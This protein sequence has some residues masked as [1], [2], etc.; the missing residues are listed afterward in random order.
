MNWLNE[1]GLKKIGKAGLKALLNLLVPRWVLL[2]VI[3]LGAAA[4]GG[5]L[6]ETVQKGTFQIRQMVITGTLCAKMTPGMW[7]QLFSDIVTLPK[8]ETFFFTQ[9]AEGGEAVDRSIEVRF[10]DGSLCH[11]SGTM[12]IIL[13]TSEQKAIDLV[14]RH[15]YRTYNDL[16]QKLILPVVRNA[17]RLTANLMSARESYSEKRADFV[18][19]A[20]DQIQNGLYETEEETRKVVDPVSGQEVT[21]IFK[22]IKRDGDGSPIYQH[23][24]LDGVGVTLANFEVKRFGYAEK[25][26]AQIATQQ[27]ALMAVATA[28][29]KAQQAEQEALM[30]EAEGKANVAREKYK[31]EQK[32]VRAI[33]QAQQRLEVAQ[34]DR[35]AAA[36]KKQEE[37]LLGQGEAERKR[38]I[39]QA[40]GALKQKLEA[41][42][43]AQELWAGAFAQRQVPSLVMGGSGASDTDKATTEFAQMMQLL[44][45]SQMGLDLS[46]TKG[47][48]VKGR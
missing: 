47:V 45:A 12:R 46:I 1:P 7:P 3:V 41:Y 40:D 31:E 5:R 10:V 2:A 32:K 43:R 14:S 39:L 24:P 35:Q 26:R 33:V 36:E 4:V 42:V 28:V 17:L 21:K 48:T 44:V 19:S 15:S 9:D 20:W 29:A 25:V 23:N 22:I 11:V 34:L 16:Q 6:V 37:I 27:E 13:P 38:L 18:F 30:A 8:A